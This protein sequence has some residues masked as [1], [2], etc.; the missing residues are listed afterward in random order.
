MHNA[1]GAPVHSIYEVN[2]IACID[3][4]SAIRMFILM[5][6]IVCVLKIIKCFGD[7]VSLILVNGT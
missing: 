1:Y 5:H 3:A 6:T 7:S 2:Y 4:C